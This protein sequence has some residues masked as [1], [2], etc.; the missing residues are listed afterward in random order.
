LEQLWDL[1]L[2]TKQVN[3]PQTKPHIDLDTVAKNI[4]R[5]LKDQGEESFVVD[6]VSNPARQVLQ[7]K[8]DIVKYIIAAKQAEDAAR[9]AKAKHAAELQTLKAIVAE[10]KLASLA[11]KDIGTLEKRIQ[12]LEAGA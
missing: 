1:P 6:S 7:N 12:E 4:N 9:A 5:Q 10:K 11:D 3:I 8:L 2:L